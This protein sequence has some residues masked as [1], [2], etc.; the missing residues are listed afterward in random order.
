MNIHQLEL[1]N[2]RFLMRTQLK[3]YETLGLASQS[4]KIVGFNNENLKINGNPGL[5]I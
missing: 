5:A 1:Q 4:S 3:I 2:V